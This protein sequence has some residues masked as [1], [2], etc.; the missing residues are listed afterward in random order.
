MQ[1][2]VCVEISVFY[3]KQAAGMYAPL[4]Y[5]L[6][7]ALIEIPYTVFSCKQL[8]YG[9]ITCA[10]IH[11]EW[12]AIKF[13]VVSPFH[14][15][16]FHVFHVLRHDGCRVNPQRAAHG[17]DF[18]GV[19]FSLEPFLR[20]LDIERKNAQVVGWVLLDLSHGMDALWLNFIAI[21]GRR[22]TLLHRRFWCPN[23]SEG[24]HH[25]LLEIPFRLVELCGG[26]LHLLC[27]GFLAHI[28]VCNQFFELPKSVNLV[29]YNQQVDSG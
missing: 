24:L 22:H 9:A 7:Q 29:L 28:C 12:K 21:G 14:V 13:F 27:R 18:I 17:C 25:K 11:F 19:L 8:V 23:H 5:A 20:L 2:I 4:P 26:S 3:R 1:P 15:P 16:H 6:A 10:M